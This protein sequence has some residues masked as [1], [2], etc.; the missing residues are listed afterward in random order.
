MQNPYF[1]KVCQTLRIW[2]RADQENAMILRFLKNMIGVYNIQTAFVS[3]Y[4]KLIAVA[5]HHMYK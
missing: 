5:L 1:N 2:I 3:Q 4:M